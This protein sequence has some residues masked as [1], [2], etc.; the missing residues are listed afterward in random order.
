M[1]R[2]VAVPSWRRGVRLAAGVAVGALVLAA[3]GGDPEG[4]VEGDSG[5]GSGSGS[6]AG[7]SISDLVVDV[8]AE[9]D[10]LDPF[11]RNTA[12]AMRFYRLAYSTILQWNEDGSVAPD[13]AAEL[14][15]VSEDG[16]TWTISLQEGVTFHDGSALT[17]DDVVYSFEQAA[18]PENGSVWLSALS[19]MESVEAVDD[20]TVVLELDEPYAY[21]T[22]RLAMIPIMSEE[23]DYSANDTYATTENGSGPY[24][25]GELNRGESIVMERYPDYFGDEPPYETITFQIVPE[26]A[27]R[28]ARLLNDESHILPGIPTEQVENIQQR[29]ANAQVVENNITRVFLYPSQN[30]GRPTADTDFRLAVAYAADRQRIVDQVYAGAGRP[31]STYLT[32]GSEHHDEEL[33]LHFGPEP[34]LDKAREHLEASG[35]ELDR[36]L[37]IIAVNKPSVVSAATILQANLAEIGIEATVE[38]QEVAGFYPALASGEY[39]LIAFDSPASTSSG[40]APDNVYGGLHST[41][42]NNFAGFAD[43]EMDALLDAAVTAQTED[44]QAAAW[45]AVSERDIETQGNI[46]LVVAQT[47]EAWSS[48]LEGYEPSALLWLNTVLDVN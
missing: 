7:T 19:Y 26:D 18:D 37:S 38:G 41:A 10:S 22:S 3:C 34:N 47:S 48:D 32:Y 6:Q 40:F 29:G 5:T 14:P 20:T 9:P 16:L 13:L 15:E 12:E 42:A 17:A 1:T 4:D 39:D 35:V 21:M 46:Q 23:S 33:G 28:I 2:K 8:S 31:N 43:P 30:E 25:L 45:R 11:Y 44:Q 24:M 36:P 27:S